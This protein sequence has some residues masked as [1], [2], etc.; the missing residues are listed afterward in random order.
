MLASC[1]TDPEL[2]DA[3]CRIVG[4]LD[5]PRGLAAL[6]PLVEREI[7]YRLLAEPHGAARRRTAAADSHLA[8][9]AR[10][11][12]RIRDRLDTLRVAE[13]AAAAGSFHQHFKAVTRLA[14]IEYQKQLRLQEARRLMLSLGTSASAAAF[15]VGYESPSPFSREYTRLFGVPPGRDAR[16]SQTEGETLIAA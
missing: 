8:R 5:R 2:I 1:P 3:A 14:P 12:A 7:L 10:A 6:A 9:V 15:A 11:I 13:L 4:L 16:R